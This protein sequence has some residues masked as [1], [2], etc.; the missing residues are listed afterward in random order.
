MKSIARS[1]LRRAAPAVAALVITTASLSAAGRPGAVDFGVIPGPSGHGEQVEVHVP[2]NL[3]SIAA[4]IVAREQPEVARLLGSIESVHVRVVGLDEGNRA[5]VLKRV[6][7]VRSELARAGW[8]KIVS[9]RDGGDDVAI[10]MQTTA[11]ETI[12]GVALTV[13]GGDS[14]AVFIN[15]VGSI[16]PEELAEIAEALRV[17]HLAHVAAIIEK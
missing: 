3:V 1:L 4:K 5:A 17:P 9:A 12:E 14:E 13:L 8:Q 7:E 10:F 11:D 15:V 2:R 16:R 6:D